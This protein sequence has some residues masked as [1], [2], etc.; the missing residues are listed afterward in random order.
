MKKVFRALKLRFASK[1]TQE[2]TN[3]KP[4]DQM[5]VRMQLML[6]RAKKTD[7]KKD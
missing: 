5:P 3:F 6:L 2:K 7:Q 4:L 1:K